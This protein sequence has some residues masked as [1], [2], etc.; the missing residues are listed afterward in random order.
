MTAKKTALQ[1][2]VDV[3]QMAVA[4]FV[5][6]GHE[7]AVERGANGGDGQ[8]VGGHSSSYPQARAAQRLAD[9][10]HAFQQEGIIVN[11]GPVDH[12]LRYAASLGH[13]CCFADQ[14][15]TDPKAKPGSPLLTIVDAIRALDPTICDG[16]AYR[17][18]LDRAGVPQ[19]RWE[20]RI[21]M[22]YIGEGDE[23]EPWSEVLAVMAHDADQAK[24]TA[25]QL[26]RN[27][28]TREMPDAEVS[29]TVGAPKEAPALD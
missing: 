6:L 10:L 1:N 3:A 21:E 2:L 16:T 11:R 28:L 15:A 4:D 9:A 24:W 29:M 5:Q 17:G 20:V 7:E 23:G 18:I 27:R 12:A 8:Y 13:S 19:K 22:E 26:R 25:T 14:C